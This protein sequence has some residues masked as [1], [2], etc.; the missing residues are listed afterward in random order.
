MG[1]ERDKRTAGTYIATVIANAILFVIIN[2]IP[3]WNLRFVTAEYPAVL[4]ALNLSVLAQVAVNAVLI[5]FHPHVLHYTARIAL[6]IPSL[7]AVI[8]LI[9]VF[10]FDLSYL[11]SFANTLLRIIFYIGL[12]GTVIGMIV[13]TFKLIGG[14]FRRTG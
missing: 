14:V 7:L 9:T 3:D 5:F 8:I 12:V 2:K 1:E 4:W 11:F 6:G 13:D 10:P